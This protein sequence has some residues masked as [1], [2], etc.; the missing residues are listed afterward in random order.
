MATVFLALPTYDGTLSA[1]TA[2]AAYGTASDQHRVLVYPLGKSLLAANCN[3]LLAACY[4]TADKV[5]GIDWFAMLHADMAP[6]P[7][8]LDT[9]I[10]EAEEHGADLMSAVVPI[11]NEKGLTSTAIGN[12]RESIS[13]FG[14]L[15]MQQVH[16]C[17]CPQTFDVSAIASAL[18]RMDEPHRVD[19]CPRHYLLANTGCMVFRL[20]GRSWPLS[21]CFEMRDGL[22]RR[23]DG[24]VQAWGFSEDWYFSRAVADAGGKVYC[25]SAV[26]VEHIGSAN[27]PNDRAWGTVAN[28]CTGREAIAPC[29]AS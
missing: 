15:T 7:L 10:E 21:V 5:G 1:R 11:K 18:E 8:W 14:R 22:Y 27:Y 20:A 16:S 25:T 17:W 6:E 4:N 3:S 28:D 19:K 23:A 12:D 26:K 29:G 9:L 24:T 2:E 13:Q